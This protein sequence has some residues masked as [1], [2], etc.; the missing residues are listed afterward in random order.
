[1]SRREVQHQVSKP[2]PKTVR[3][4]RFG[5]SLYA[6]AIILAGLLTFAGVFWLRYRPAGHTPLEQMIAAN[7]PN[8]NVHALAYAPDG[9]AYV[10]TQLGLLQGFDNRWGRQPYGNVQAVQFAGGQLFAAGESIGLNRVAADHKLEPLLQGQ[11][12]AFAVDEAHPQ[13]MVALV[14]PTDLQE[15]RDGGQTWTR[16]TAFQGQDLLTVTMDPKDGNRL[17]VGGLNGYVALSPDGGRTWTTPSALQGTVSAL[18]FD[19]RKP[20][21]LWTAAGGTV[22]STENG[23]TSWRANKVKGDHPVIALA[24][25]PG[26]SQGPR[27][28]AADGFMFTLD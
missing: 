13:H 4:G 14:G 5:T 18:A 2:T 9:T 16:L 24:F 3:T 8:E 28:I 21:R 22:Q 7:E 17:A 6:W 27:C 26:S 10:G 25:A 15:T 19:P 12:R 23:G 1:M 11:V 20:G